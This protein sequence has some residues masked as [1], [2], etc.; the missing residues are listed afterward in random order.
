MGIGDCGRPFWYKALL[1]IRCFDMIVGVNDIRFT[2]ESS[3]E[4]CMAILKT[5]PCPKVVNFVR[6]G[7]SVKVSKQL[8]MSILGLYSDEPLL[9]VP[10][11][12]T[13]QP[14]TGQLGSPEDR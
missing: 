2:V 6:Y 8:M 7:K 12:C 10:Q 13:H 9:S 11:P 5:A 4:E 14:L 1:T 3:Q